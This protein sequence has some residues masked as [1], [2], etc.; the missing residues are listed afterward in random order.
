MRWMGHKSQAR[1]EENHPL[2]NSIRKHGV[3]NFTFT[4][5]HEFDTQEEADAKEIEL[6]ILHNT[7]DRACGYNLHPGGNRYAH[8]AETRAKLSAQKIAFYQK[9]LEETG[10]KITEDERQKLSEAHKGKPSPKKGKRT[11]VPGWNK[12]LH[13]MTPDLKAKLI[14]SRKGKSPWNK[15]IPSKRKGV[16]RFTPEEQADIKERY[17]SGENSRLLAKVYN[18]SPTTIMKIVKIN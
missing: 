17:A 8:S 3:E 18:C 16:F 12:G 10:S 4:V 14:A 6:I 9:R 11:G 15:G 2:Y 7:L 5:L 13:T 1:C